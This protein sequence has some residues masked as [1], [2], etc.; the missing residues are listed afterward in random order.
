MRDTETG[1]RKVEAGPHALVHAELVEKARGF[2]EAARAENTGRAY[3]SDWKVFAAWCQAQDLEALPA[4]PETVALYLTAR[5]E[6]GAKV[7]TIARALVSLSQGHKAAGL[8]SPRGS[9]A[10]TAVMKGI[11]RS[12][13]VDA[14]QVTG[15]EPPRA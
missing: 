8:D 14:S 4:E 13:G 3:S 11:R 5:V 7:S 6:E 10:V 9:A 15:Q 12:L 2:A 1:I